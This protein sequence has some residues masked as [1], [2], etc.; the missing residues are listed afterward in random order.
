MSEIHAGAESAEMEGGKREIKLT[1][2]ALANEIERLQRE[3]KITVNKIKGLIPHMKS[4]M[5][6][7]GNVQNVTPLL[8]SLIQLCENATTS[9]EMLIPL[10]PQDEMAKQNTWFTTIMDY[11]SAFKVKVEQWLNEPIQEAIE[12]CPVQPNEPISSSNIKESQQTHL[13]I[14]NQLGDAQEEVHLIDNVSNV[15][16]APRSQ[17]SAASSV[18]SARLRAEADLAALQV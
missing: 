9:H 18:S 8:E 17:T 7:R 15:G 3:R 10:L 16:R 2:K 14:G 11:S 1:A 12:S 13:A 5:A 6:K 4:L